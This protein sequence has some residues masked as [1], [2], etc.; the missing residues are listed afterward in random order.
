MKNNLY[1]LSR[2]KFVR[3]C[4]VWCEHHSPPW[5]QQRSYCA[6][7]G[8]RGGCN[9][10]VLWAQGTARAVRFLCGG[11]PYSWTPPRH[12]S[13]LGQR[14]PQRLRNRGCCA[15]PEI[16]AFPGPLLDSFKAF[17]GPF[18]WPLAVTHPVLE[19]TTPHEVESQQTGCHEHFDSLCNIR[20]F[21]FIA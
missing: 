8:A 5:A 6:C 11:N 4:K 10:V 16:Q 21:G 9:Q 1:D 17:L 13:I 7:R 14:S 15:G 19:D 18:S 12:L 2:V 20:S 3:V